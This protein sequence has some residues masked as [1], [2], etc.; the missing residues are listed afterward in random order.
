MMDF[1][2]A[3][4]LACTIFSGIGFAVF[5]YGKKEKAI[6][7]AVIGAALMAYS[8]FISETLYLYLI[9]IALIGVLFI[10]RD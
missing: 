1:S 5:I 3:K 6:P 10:W 7:P 4:I 8:Y 9:G 2:P